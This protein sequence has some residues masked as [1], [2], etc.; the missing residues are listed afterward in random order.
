[1]PVRTTITA[2]EPARPGEVCGEGMAEHTCQNDPGHEPPHGCACGTTWESALDEDEAAFL[3]RYN[4]RDYEPVAVTVDLAFFTIR[5]GHLAV[6]LQRRAKHPFRGRWAMPGGFVRPREDLEEAVIREAREK[7]GQVVE[8][9]YI[10]QLGTFGAVDRD[11]RMR[12]FSVTYLVFLPVGT[13]PTA[14][15]DAADARWWA[16][17]DV[18]A[19]DGPGLAF[20]HADILAL[21]IERVRSKLEYTT[22]AAAFLQEP[23][24]VGELRRI[25]EAVWG[26]T[27]HHPNFARKMTGVEGFL[28]PAD[29]RRTQILY[30]RGPARMIMPPYTRPVT[31]TGA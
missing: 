19:A 12:T 21:G 26:T 27:L 2:H 6:L 15:S 9:W 16:V 14:G 18:F 31:T 1:M 10:E 11:P 25:Y 7:T 30:R 28:V 17:D 5:N 20:D 29:D 4:P 13:E 23:F 3:A 22:L 8:P 24:T